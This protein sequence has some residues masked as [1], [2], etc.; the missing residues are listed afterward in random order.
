MN[1][2]NKGLIGLLL[3]TAVGAFASVPIIQSGFYVD[4]SA[5]LSDIDITGFFIFV[6]LVLGLS[7]NGFINRQFKAMV[8]AGGLFMAIGQ[9]A[10]AFSEK[11]TG[12][13]DEI[14]MMLQVA[15]VV[16]CT[17]HMS[18]ERLFHMGHET[19]NL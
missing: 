1:D 13:S 12:L 5:A 2:T 6:G 4:F 14:S 15:S 3:L 11:M 9:L 17:W 18:F 19:S 7:T 10:S 8:F 16:F